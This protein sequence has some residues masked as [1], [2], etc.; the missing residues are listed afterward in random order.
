MGGRGKGGRSR[1]YKKDNIQAIG[2]ERSLKQR[3]EEEE[4][5]DR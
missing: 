1:N 2:N 3:K 4:K 5:A